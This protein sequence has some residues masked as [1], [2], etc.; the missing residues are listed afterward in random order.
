MSLLKQMILAEKY[1]VRLNATQLAAELGIAVTTL[2][3]MR[4][5]GTL[6]VRT[7]IDLGKLWADV[8]DVAEYFERVR[9]RASV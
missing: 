9:E 6:G 3:R 8:Q 5:A 1:G 4:S 7:Y 2:H